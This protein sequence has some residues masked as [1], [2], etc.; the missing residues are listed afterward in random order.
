MQT[1]EEVSS[2]QFPRDQYL[3]PP[4]PGSSRRTSS[5]VDGRER[6]LMFFWE[7]PRTSAVTMIRTQAPYITRL[8]QRFFGTTVDGRF[9]ELTRRSIVNYARA[10]GQ[11]FAPTTPATGPLLAYALSTALLRGGRVAFPPAMEYPDTNRPVLA[12]NPQGRDY[13]TIYGMDVETGQ[14]VPLEP[15]ADGFI[16]P[17]AHTQVPSQGQA[18]SR[19]GDVTNIY[20]PSNESSASA[21]STSTSTS[22]N[23]LSGNT[24]SLPGLPSLPNFTTA[25]SQPVGQEPQVDQPPDYHGNPFI[26]PMPPGGCPKGFTP[27]G[28]GYCKQTAFVR[29]DG[30][31]FL[32]NPADLPVAYGV[33][34]TYPLAFDFLKKSDDKDKD[35]IAEA[36]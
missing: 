24:V 2:P 30:F 18:T 23:I 9:G 5:W 28:E 33:P 3:L 6:A 19:V 8:I 29:I 35:K 34:Q 26:R 32:P 13:S 25:Q 36:Y 12:S 14:E 17:V 11:N 31:L 4:R 27:F 20:A 21:T 15:A 7:Q 1:L 22:T 10:H 16:A